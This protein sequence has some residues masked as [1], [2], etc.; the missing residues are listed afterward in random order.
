MSRKLHT[1]APDSE[2]QLVALLA[3]LRVNATEEADFEGRFLCEF[4]ERVAREAVCCPARRH[5]FTHMLQ[6]L[7]NLG[8][9]RLA[10]GA[11]AMGLCVLAVGYAMYPAET[12]GADTTASVA[13]ENH[14]SPLVLPVLSDDL[15][16]CTTIR[17]EPAH[18]AF[19]VG[20]VTIIRGQHSTVIEVPNTTVISVP[21]RQGNYT[22]LPATSVRYAF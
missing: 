2:E 12:A 9:G 16:E 17:V 6:M 8:R 14:A 21:Q 10:F 15:A 3:T 22:Q 5:M 13:G 20:G 1:S 4:H 11:S 7:E 19:E 18:S